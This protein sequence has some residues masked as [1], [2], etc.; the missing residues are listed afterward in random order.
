MKAFFRKIPVVAVSFTM[1]LVFGACSDDSSGSG[2]DH[3]EI[4][5]PLPD[6]FDDN[7][8]G[9]SDSVEKS[10]SS[11]KV[12]SSAKETS[13]SSKNVSS[14]AKESSS[15]SQKTS[16]SA[17][18]SSS[19]AKPAS[20][21]ADTEKSWR[22]VCLDILNEYR[23]TEGAKP[24]TLANDDKQ[25]CT[26]QQAAND[27]KDNAA[28]GHFG[29]CGESAQNTGPNVNMAWKSDLADIAKYYIDMMW[30]EKKLVENGTRDPDKKEDFSYI[31]HYLNIRN[32]KYTK[33]SCGFATSS[34]KKTGWLNI[35]FF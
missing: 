19:T 13:S 28:H 25:T 12:S 7:T 14:S 2:V 8:E 5:I 23:A 21:S 27:L 34:D 35:N 30:D 32:A 6:G 22:E 15:S 31:G 24:L 26:D 17:T 20:S 10:S 18:S 29:D 4:D 11:K 33:V 16:S 1:A 3:G 9:S